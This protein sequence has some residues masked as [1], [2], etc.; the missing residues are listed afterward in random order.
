M[1]KAESGLMHRAES[2]IRDLTTK[3]KRNASRLISV[4]RGEDSDPGA[5]TLAPE[6]EAALRTFRAA[7]AI[8]PARAPKVAVV[9]V[10][11]G[12]KSRLLCTLFGDNDA[13]LAKASIDTTDKL[14]KSTLPNGLVVIDTPGVG[15]DKDVFENVTRAYLGIEQVDGDDGSDAPD[16]MHRVE[17][18]PVCEVG[19]QQQCPVREVVPCEIHKET[20]TQIVVPLTFQPVEQTIYKRMYWDDSGS[21]RREKPSTIQLEPCCKAEDGKPCRYLKTIKPGT[22]DFAALQPD[23]VLVLAAGPR[24]GL[25]RAEKQFVKLLKASSL[26]QRVVLVVNLWK[27]QDGMAKMDVHRKVEEQTGESV[28]AVNAFTGDG[29]RDLV[30]RVFQRLPPS[31]ATKFNAALVDNLRQSRDHLASNLVLKTAAQ[32]AITRTDA[33]V[34]VG[35]S[36]LPE[37]QKLIMVMLDRLSNLHR[38]PDSDWNKVGGDY[39]KFVDEAISADRFAD[40]LRKNG[41]EVEVVETITEPE[42]K[43]QKILIPRSGVGGWLSKTWLG[44]MFGMEQYEYEVREITV[45]VSKQ[46]RSRHIEPGRGG[47]EG[48]RLALEVGIGAH[49]RLWAAY[50]SIQGATTDNQSI[51]RHVDRLLQK[52]GSARLNEL[53][54]EGSEKKVMDDL[55]EHLPEN[56]LHVE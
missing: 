24:G 36:D 28:V 56:W 12:G 11:S 35:E 44:E 54:Q 10:T 3:T 19:N 42:V 25:H 17:D 55:V 45:Q 2:R 49:H 5:L 38:I 29:V 30:R 21:M 47:A 18:V 26:G 43:E 41:V 8:D 34:K 52:V 46:I 48:V 50:Q 39:E 27:S 7:A 37:Q 33:T 53:C 13:F 9:G 23:V 4:L 40:I 32:C 6:D 51:S 31:T 1:K 22:S 20:A 15:G 14:F 16:A